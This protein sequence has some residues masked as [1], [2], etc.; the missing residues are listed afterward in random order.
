MNRYR[1]TFIAVIVL[2]FLGVG[3][4]PLLSDT[5]RCEVRMVKGQ[6]IYAP[7]YSHI[8]HGDK[9]RPL[10]L[11]VTLSIRNTDPVHAIDLVTVDYFDT[12]GKKVRSYLGSEMKLG[13]MSSTRYVIPES[14]SSGGSGAN[15]I[16]R[17]KSSEKV[18]EPIV[19]TIMISTRTQQGISFTSRGQVIREDS[20]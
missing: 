12:D 18:S 17:W 4:T 9:E 14:D 13:P 20:P 2:N 10:D 3:M 15:F 8:Y 1:K 11:A 16:V 7:A 19:E 6:T 5:A